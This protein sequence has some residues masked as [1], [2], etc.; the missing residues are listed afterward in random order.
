MVGL[1]ERERGC[2][3]SG[4][5]VQQQTAGKPHKGRARRR[6]VRQRVGGGGVDVQG[7]Q[8]AEGL[9]GFGD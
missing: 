4:Q 8:T 3:W 7:P 6:R 9:R 1:R 2:G 5:K